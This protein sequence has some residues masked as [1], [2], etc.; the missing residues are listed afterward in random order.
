MDSYLLLLISY[1]V[2][3]VLGYKKFELPIISPTMITLVFFND[4]YCFGIL[5]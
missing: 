3:V 4:C 1:V 5:V 2:F